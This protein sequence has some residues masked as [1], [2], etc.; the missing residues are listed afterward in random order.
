MLAIA[1]LLHYF[2]KKKTKKRMGDPLLVAAITRSYSPRLSGL[3]TI[4]LFLAV[5]AGIIAALNPG[6]TA[7]TDPV[8]RNGIDLAIVLD[9]SKSMLATDLAPSRLERA[10]QFVIRLIDALP[11]DRIA[12]V[13][14]AGKAY[15]Q[16]PLTTDHG[17]ARLFVASAG[18][19][20]VPRQG[21]VLSEAMELGSR[22]FPETEKRFKSIILI[23]DGEDHDNDALRKARELAGQGVMINT[24]GVG[25]PAGGT[26]TDP[27]TGLLKT[28]EAGNTVIT[29]LNEE[30]LKQVASATNG[31][32]I[33]LQSSDA[34]VTAMKKQ[35]SQIE[36][37]AFT[38][39]SLLDFRTFFMWFAGAM[40]LFGVTEIFIPE[41]RRVRT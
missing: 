1:Y 32:Y 9:V 14:F 23:S 19:D 25:S 34:A 35:L 26:I 41:K 37:K 39:A 10:R 40:L 21:T 27:S 3:K 15:L 2:W 11:D 20:A 38:D 7:G 5:T 22:A 18:P 31:I 8:K 13:V 16:M 4:L 29:R 30:I 33:S 6:Q 36:R 17:A 28:D 24:V 12:L